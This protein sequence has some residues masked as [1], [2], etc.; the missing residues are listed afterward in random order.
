MLAYA[1]HAYLC[2]MDTTQVANHV[3]SEVIITDGV[4]ALHGPHLMLCRLTQCAVFTDNKAVTYN[5]Q[6][7]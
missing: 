5:I 3:D 7:A 4:F 6:I 1:V 2:L